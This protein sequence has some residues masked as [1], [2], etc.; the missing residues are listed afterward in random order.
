VKLP[1][2]LPPVDLAGKSI[3]N[4]YS[5]AVLSN[6]MLKV[7]PTGSTIALLFQNTGCLHL[8]SLDAL[9]N[10][11]KITR[12]SPVKQNLS[13]SFKQ[14]SGNFTPLSMSMPEQS[15]PGSSTWKTFFSAVRF[16]FSTVLVHLLSY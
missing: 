12:L 2:S 10:T 14:Q 15:S 8:L 5:S 11:L 9:R 4:S 7:S 3:S 6:M 1:I 16:T 13:T